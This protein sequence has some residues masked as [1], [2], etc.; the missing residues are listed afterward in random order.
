[1]HGVE[2]SCRR[3]SKSRSLNP[4]PKFVPLLMK[5]I[6]YNTIMLTFY[7]FVTLYSDLRAT[8]VLENVQ[9]GASCIPATNGGTEEEL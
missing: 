5:T 8:V 1:M 3:V 2:N 6:H 7:P 9:R 4:P